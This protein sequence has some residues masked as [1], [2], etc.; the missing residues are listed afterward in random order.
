M[1]RLGLNRQKIAA[2]LIPIVNSS[3]VLATYP[4]QPDRILN[5]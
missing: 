3:Q 1:P 4:F 2:R 5:T